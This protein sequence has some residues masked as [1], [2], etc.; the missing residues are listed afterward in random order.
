MS[1]DFWD[2]HV[3]VDHEGTLF[4]TYCTSRQGFFCKGSGVR[5]LCVP[6]HRCAA[7]GVVVAVENVQIHLAGLPYVVMG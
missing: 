7:V 5:K 3:D 2:R 1:C 6:D 4:N